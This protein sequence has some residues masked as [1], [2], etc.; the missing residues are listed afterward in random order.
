M[1]RALEGRESPEHNVFKICGQTE[2]ETQM[3]IEGEMVD[4]TNEMEIGDVSYTQDEE[5]SSITT[6]ASAPEAPRSRYGRKITRTKRLEESQSQ[7]RKGKGRNWA[8]ACMAEDSSETLYEEP[9]KA[10]DKMND[11]MS[12]SAMI[13]DT[14]YLHQAMKQPDQAQFLKAMVKEIETHQ[15]ENIGRLPLENKYPRAL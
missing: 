10:L 7:S 9:T 2:L 5:T 15:K 4:S 1:T 14:M 8:M 13:G 6:E 11:L 12:L 3:D